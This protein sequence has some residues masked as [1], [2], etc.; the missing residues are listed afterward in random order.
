MYHFPWQYGLYIFL[1]LHMILW[2]GHCRTATIDDDLNNTTINPFSNVSTWAPVT[3]WKPEDFPN[4][5]V[6]LERCGRQGQRSYVCD[7]NHLISPS[8]ANA[9]DAKIQ[10]IQQTTPCACT[11]GTCEDQGFGY[12]I[13]IAIVQEVFIDES[14]K[15][16]G[17]ESHLQVE[18]FAHY[19]RKK[20]WKFG[21]CG[22]DVVVVLAVNDKKIFTSAGEDAGSVISSTC[23]SK[24][25]YHAR[26]R[27]TNGQYYAGLMS[28]LNDYKTYLIEGDCPVIE[29]PSVAG[30]VLG[31]LF[32]SIVVICVLF[33]IFECVKR[34]RA[35][36]RRRKKFNSFSTG[37]GVSSISNPLSSPTRRSY[38]HAGMSPDYPGPFRP[39]ITS[40]N[41]FSSRVAR[42]DD[43]HKNLLKV[44]PTHS[45]SSSGQHSRQ[46]SDGRSSWRL[47]KSHDDVGKISDA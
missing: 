25:F 21:T 37:L 41:P 12:I 28:T 33:C 2:L 43:D 11:E 40:T 9:L 39:N 46:S 24:A 16:V 42:T 26:Y 27:F 17:E 6:D 36:E 38:S 13:S 10:E 34:R 32:A 1:V 45:R 18:R 5:Q 44:Q 19:L 15:N 29:G 35:S 23:I 14:V 47:G 3:A 20:S 22:N 7:P 31:S 4:P 8:D 30:I